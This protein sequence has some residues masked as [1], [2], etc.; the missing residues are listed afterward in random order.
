MAISFA[1]IVRSGSIVVVQ[2]VLAL[3]LCSIFYEHIYNGED[4]VSDPTCIIEVLLF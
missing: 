3:N 1:F 2:R 4:V